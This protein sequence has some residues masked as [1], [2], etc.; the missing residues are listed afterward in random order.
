MQNDNIDEIIDGIK[1]QK[2]K[3]GAEKFLKNKLSPEQSKKLSD[4]LSD[5]NALKNL[6]SSDRAKELFKKLGGKDATFLSLSIS[7]GLIGDLLSSIS[8]EDMERLKNVASSLMSQS[9][10]EPSSAPKEQGAGGNRNA[11]NADVSSLFGGDM[12]KTLMTV[13]TQMNK[14]DDNTRFIS[15][16]RPLLSEDRRKK[17]D[18]AMKFLKLMEM[19]PLLKG[20]FNV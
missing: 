6:L 15:A 11:P 19:L 8:P 17:A 18:E 20:F 3:K 16:L 1:S 12:A 13:A 2:S 4:V 5:E 10:S 7:S 14:E 9:G